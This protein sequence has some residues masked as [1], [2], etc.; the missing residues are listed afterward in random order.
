MQIDYTSKSFAGIPYKGTAVSLSGG[1]IASI[2]GAGTGLVKTLAGA[3]AVGLG[4]ALLV[5]GAMLSGVD[6]PVP[7][8][9]S[10]KPIP[11]APKIPLGQTLVRVRTPRRD[12][13]GFCIDE[14][15]KFKC[16]DD[17]IKASTSVVNRIFGD[18]DIGMLIVELIDGSIF[19]NTFIESP[20]K[21]MSV[22]GVQ[23][24]AFPQK[25]FSYIRHWSGSERQRRMPEFESLQILIQGASVT[26]VTELK[27]NLTEALS[28]NLDQIIDILG[29]DI[30]SKFFNVHEI[31]KVK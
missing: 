9:V 28:Q 11:K 5:G 3:G 23:N 31:K 22:A 13:L 4:L 14:T 18:L 1:D 2:I 10:T 21:F 27:E 19:R 20:L 29:E 17:Q 7:V 8:P 26:Q 24:I 15:L 16:E 30:L 6:T 25:D 12:F